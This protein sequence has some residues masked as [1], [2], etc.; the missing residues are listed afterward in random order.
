MKK[1]PSCEREIDKYGIAC[2]Y[3][4][5]VTEEKERDKGN[6]DPK[7]KKSDKGKPRDERRF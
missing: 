3:C 7:D 2:Q 4:G 5:R 6:K 1:C